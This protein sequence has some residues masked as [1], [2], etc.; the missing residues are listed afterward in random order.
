MVR[1]EGA[2]DGERAAVEVDHRLARRDGSAQVR[3]GADDEIT[4][5]ETPRST[6][7][8]GGQVDAASG[9]AIDLQ[10]TGTALDEQRAAAG[11]VGLAVDV[12][13]DADGTLLRGDVEETRTGR[14]RIRVAVS[15]RDVIARAEEVKIAAALEGVIETGGKCRGA[16]GEVEH[17]QERH[18]LARR[19]DG[20]HAVG[21]GGR[22][23]GAEGDGAGTEGAG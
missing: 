9:V 5:V 4:G 3:V 2:V 22:T 6:Y 12:A 15:H 16:S 13:V 17:V 11:T 8:S 20:A 1:L 21:V 10:D 7:E 19:A 14:L 23:A 18:I